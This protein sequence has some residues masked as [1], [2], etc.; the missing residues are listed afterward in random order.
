MTYTLHLQNQMIKLR[1]LHQA[2]TI[3]S[4]RCYTAS[5]LS[6]KF[7]NP[8]SNIGAATAGIRLFY[9]PIQTNNTNFFNGHKL[10]YFATTPN[11]DDHINQQNLVVYEAP[12]ASLAKRLKRI[13]LASAVASIIGVP[14]LIFF[15]SGDVPAVGQAAVGATAILAATGST[16]ALTFC[17]SPY[18][19]KLEWI[20]VRQCTTIAQKEDEKQKQG[21]EKDIQCG[22][23]ASSNNMLL[24]ATTTNI[25][26]MQTETI[27]DPNLDVIHGKDDKSYRPF[28]NFMIKGKPFYVHP[29]LIDN[30]EI[31]IMLVGKEKGMLNF[32]DDDENSANKKNKKDLDDEFL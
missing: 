2:T 12:F 23:A 9:S 20:P 22:A 15:N 14:T 13:S 21:E 25:F 4:R 19:N 32:E 29:E 1:L 11:D 7:T 31:R 16:A 27:F 8:Q 10:R 28:C 24:K 3:V 5:T 17:F 30:E 26:A 18:V 6:S